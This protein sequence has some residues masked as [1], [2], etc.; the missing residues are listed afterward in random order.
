MAIVLTAG[1]VPGSLDA[2]SAARAFASVTTSAPASGAPANSATRRKPTHAVIFISRSPFCGWCGSPVHVQAERDAPG[3]Q[4]LRLSPER[5]VASALHVA[6]QPLETGIAEESGAAG[7][8]HRELDGANGGAS[9]DGP[10]EHHFIR[11]L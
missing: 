11:R 3:V 2:I 9:G 6:E 5:V 1:G 7:H 4:A 8:L 10:R